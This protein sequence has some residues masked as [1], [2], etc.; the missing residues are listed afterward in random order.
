MGRATSRETQVYMRGVY[1]SLGG[2]RINLDKLQ[3][4]LPANEREAQ[5]KTLFLQHLAE[6]GC[7][8]VGDQH[9]ISC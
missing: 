2:L 1:S 8:Q 6:R 3:A 5:Q 9:P 7:K 4:Y